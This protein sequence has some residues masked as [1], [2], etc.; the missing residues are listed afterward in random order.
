MKGRAET[1]T[2]KWLARKA[3]KPVYRSSPDQPDL[4]ENWTSGCVKGFNILGIGT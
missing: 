1:L 4:G 2:V 3:K